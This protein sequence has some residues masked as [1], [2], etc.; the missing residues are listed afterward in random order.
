MYR[1]INLSPYDIALKVGDEKNLIKKGNFA[2][3]ESKAEE[4]GFQD[5]LMYS[6]VVD[7]GNEGAKPLRAFKGQLFFSEE[8]RSI[9]VITPK[10]GGR[11]GR[12]DFT[13]IT[14]SLAKR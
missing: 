4:G 5:A 12:I 7:K 9:Y 2:D 14:E 11:E 10:R 8:Q 1:F 13:V 6:L 3:L